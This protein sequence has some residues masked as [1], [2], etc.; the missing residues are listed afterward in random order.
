MLEDLYAS[1]WHHPGVAWASAA[2]LA[3]TFL[4][5]TEARPTRLRRFLI[6]A[7]AATVLDAWLTG[8]LAPDVAKQ[9]GAL[10][11]VVFVIIGDLR[12]FYLLERG[13]WLSAIGLSLVVP[14]A[15]LIL[16]KSFP[17]TFSN[18]RTTFLVYEAAFVLFLIVLSYL[19]KPKDD[20]LSRLTAFEITQYSLW[21]LC[22]VLILAGYDWALALRF[23]PNILYYGVFL[24]F[25]AYSRSSPSPI[26][27][28]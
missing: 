5:R 24:W 2:V 28:R 22:D 12:Y 21:A 13:R 6:I 7:L 18:L 1:A 16:I 26:P 9:H 11:G 10:V 15:Q 25:V 23:V 27:A 20:F 19:R 3:L 4:A 8:A 17:E 14:A